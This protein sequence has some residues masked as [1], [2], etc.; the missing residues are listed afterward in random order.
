MSKSCLLVYFNVLLLF[1]TCHKCQ[2]PFE[3]SDIIILNAVCD[4]LK[5]LEEKL[6]FRKAE[7]KATKKKIK[8]ETTS[9]D[10]E[11]VEIP[12]KKI[13]KEE[14]PSCSKQA[15]QVQDVAYKKTTKDYSVAKDPKASEVFKS[16]FSSHQS[17]A[18]QTRAHWVTYNP[19]YN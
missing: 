19:F 13:K 10:T 16:I 4:D 12:K 11:Q 14:Q 3:D 6:T 2:K 8:Q 17:A 1:Q 7:R 5:K 9:G 15:N 18:D